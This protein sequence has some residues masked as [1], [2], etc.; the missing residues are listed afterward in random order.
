MAND[1]NLDELERL[2]GEAM[3]KDDFARASCE[4]AFPALLALAR[5]AEKAEGE[6]RWYRAAHTL[7]T[8]EG[9]AFIGCREGED[10]RLASLTNDP[11]WHPA[12]YILCSDTFGYACAD[13]ECAEYGDAEALLRLAQAEGW[14][15]LVRWVQ[16]QRQARGERAE[17]IESVRSGILEL[18]DLRAE[19]DRLRAEVERLKAQVRCAHPRTLETDGRAVECAD[20]GAIL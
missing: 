5:R 9:L 13:A 11:N 19:R 16:A 15:G 7:C 20:C 10:V 6:L 17:T 14:P 3:A 12:L 1:L 2:H 18:D 4:D 8:H